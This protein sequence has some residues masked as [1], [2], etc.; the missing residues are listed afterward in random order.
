MQFIYVCKH[1]DPGT[2]TEL[3]RQLALVCISIHQMFPPD[4]PQVVRVGDKHLYVLSHLANHHFALLCF[5][6]SVHKIKIECKVTPK[7]EP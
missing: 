3:R 1:T 2:W 4:P 5:Y 6:F 7:T